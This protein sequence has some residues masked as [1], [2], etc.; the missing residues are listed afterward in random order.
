ML[1]FLTS[2]Q[3][4]R[5]RATVLLGSNS[6]VPKKETFSFTEVREK[7]F[8]S[9]KMANKYREITVK[10]MAKEQAGWTQKRV[11]GTE[12]EEKGQG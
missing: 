11:K 5:L 6:G 7:A 9:G 10:K 2:S 3:Y 1:L 4:F 8:L 12:L